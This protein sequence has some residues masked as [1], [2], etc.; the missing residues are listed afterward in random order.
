MELPRK[1]PPAQAGPLANNQT[2]IRLLMRAASTLPEE[3]A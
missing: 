2:L 1:P 3:M